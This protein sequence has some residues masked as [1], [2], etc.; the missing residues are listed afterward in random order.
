MDTMSEPKMQHE[1][2]PNWWVLCLALAA[3]V[4]D[5]YDT[6]A[7][8]GV[9][10]PSISKEWGGVEPAHFTPGPRIYERWRGSR[11]HG[12]RTLSSKN[13]HKECHLFRRCALHRWFSADGVV[14]FNS[15]ADHPSLRD[16]AGG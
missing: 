4:L 9:S 14:K 15:G 13:G 16:R 12:G 8:G 11:L 10:I 5:G 2:K 1:I 3:V 7:L 6:V